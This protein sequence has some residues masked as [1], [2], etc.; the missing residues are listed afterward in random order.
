[1]S[2]LRRK[3]KNRPDGDNTNP[4][5]FALGMLVEVY[6]FLLLCV[7]PFLIRAGYGETSYIKYGFLVGVSYGFRLGPVPVPTLIPLA[8]VLVPAAVLHECRRTKTT[9]SAYFCSLKWSVTDRFVLLYTVALLLSSLLSSHREELLWGYP[10][11]NMG[12]A[13]QFLFVFLYFVFSRCFDAV[14]LRF[15]V[16]ASLFS[17]AVLFA[18]GILQRFGFDPLNLYNGLERKR[19]FL[20]TIGQASWFS[21]YMILFAATGVFLVWYADKTDPLYRAGAGY[22]VVASACLVTQ[23]TDSAFAGLFVALSLLFVLS[24]DSA[25]RMARFLE[26]ALIVLCSFRLTGIVRRMVQERAV[27]LDRLSVFMMEHVLVWLLIAVLAAAYWA[28]RGMR[29][30]PNGFDAGR[31]LVF[32]K[33]YASA[34]VLTV[35][36]LVVYIVFNSTGRLPE[37]LSST[38]NY[39][40]FNPRWG[41]GRG[42][43]FHDSS[44]SFL[45][46]LKDKPLQ[47][48]FGAGADQFYHVIRDYVPDWTSGASSRVLTNAHN[49]WLTAYI[50]YG[51]FGGTVYAGIFVFAIVRALKHRKE[52]PCAMAAAVCAAAYMAHNLFCYQQYICTPYMFIIMGTGEC[53][54]RGKTARSSR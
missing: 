3:K 4:F 15:F 50:N 39:L 22:L 44:L 48:L 29:N 23:N 51:L 34:L 8:A 26:T 49:E 21:S 31:F 18:I 37:A 43:T 7:Y 36:L 54:I 35:V 1:M 25:A 42:A 38:N 9:V 19:Q 12:L 52:V 24:F 45:A 16:Y 41:N 6:L 53:L 17:S 14:D 13:S 20:S 33:L 10:G 47:G 11:W 28:V 32:G 27:R 2:N 46:M 30:K 40:L 5:V